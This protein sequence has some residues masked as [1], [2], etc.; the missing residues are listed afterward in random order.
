MSELR[1]TLLILG[2]VF[3]L[4]LTWWERRRPRQA[5]APRLR[6]AS[7]SYGEAQRMGSVGPA[8]QGEP[9]IGDVGFSD[10]V[11]P[12]VSFTHTDDEI[13]TGDDEVMRAHVEPSAHG[14]LEELPMIVIPDDEARL[15][16]R[17]ALEEEQP[18]PRL[19]D[20]QAITP[21]DSSAADSAA[22]EAPIPQTL[23]TQ[24]PI[25]QA[26]VAHAPVTQ[27]PVTQLPVT[28][29][30]VTQAPVTQAPVTQAP[31]TEALPI[32]PAS[33]LPPTICG[34]VALPRV[35]PRRETIAGEPEI[36][37][38]EGVGSVRVVEPAQFGE[39]AVPPQPIVEWPPEDSRRILALR[40]V[41]AQPDRFSGRTLRLALSA[42]GFLLGKF[43]IFHKPDEAN[44]ALLSA[45]S[46]NRPGAFD[47]ETMDSQRYAGL[48]LF[49]VLPGSRTPRQAFEE[50]LATAR[51]LNERLEGALQDERGS[52]LTPL[53]V[54]GIREG[55]KAEGQ[56]SAASAHGG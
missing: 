1:W 17:A 27:L 42:E 48:S 23:I 46:L 4:A 21:E 22:A 6:E 33:N 24:A 56:T 28:Q 38:A 44:R 55:L 31:V 51:N 39:A 20:P 12:E 53:R 37:G 5:F 14:P 18:E 15:A 8:A 45:A 2:V 35:A 41:A 40:V 25:P 10:A 29:L 19:I 9:W 13:V 49:A 50:L 54:A 30:P 32:A 47:L 16:L 52:P 43:S 36:A 3:I 11:L 26:P 7:L 34:E